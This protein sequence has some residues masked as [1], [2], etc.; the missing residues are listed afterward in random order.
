M[1]IPIFFYISGAAGAFGKVQA[2]C[3]FV[4][5]KFLRLIVP[6]IIC[7]PI[8]LWPR[9]YL[10]QGMSGEVGDSRIDNAFKYFAEMMKDLPNQ[11]S[12]LWFLM[13]LFI[14]MVVCYPVVY[15]S[16]RRRKFE[17]VGT[18]DILAIVG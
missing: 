1:G 14:V 18:K 15:W 17:P 8:F 12:W 10:D 16:D 6:M 5:G 3:P 4:L 9:N 7:I 2:F 11:L 13:G